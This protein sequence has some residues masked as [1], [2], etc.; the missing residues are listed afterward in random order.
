[1]QPRPIES[2]QCSG[3]SAKKF[4][5]FGIVRVKHTIFTRTG[6]RS[7]DGRLLCS[8]KNPYFSSLRGLRQRLTISDYAAAVQ[9]SLFISRVSQINSTTL[10][11]QQ[12]MLPCPFHRCSAFFPMRRAYLLHIRQSEALAFPAHLGSAKAVF[13]SFLTMRDH[14][15]AYHPFCESTLHTSC[16]PKSTFEDQLLSDSDEVHTCYVHSL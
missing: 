9:L 6:M 5:V 11:F 4:S 10:S 7:L 15:Y 1:M 12:R 8:S 16:V 2:T 14:I 13:P 3:K